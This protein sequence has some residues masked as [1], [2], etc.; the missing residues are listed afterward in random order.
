MSS[1][2]IGQVQNHVGND[3]SFYVFNYG[4]YSIEVWDRRT[5]KLFKGKIIMKQ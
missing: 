1:A 2:R 5:T 4:N 3:K